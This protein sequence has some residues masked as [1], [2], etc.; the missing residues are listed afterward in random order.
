[1]E[2]EKK[3]MGDLKGCYAISNIT[4]DSQTHIL[5]ATED[6]GKC[7]LF[8]KEGKLEST[9][10]EAPGGTMSFAP[11]PGQ[12]GDFL[13]VQNFYP[14]FDAEKSTIAWVSHQ[15]DGSW[16]TNTVLNL[17]YV[18]RIGIITSNNIKYFVAAV[19]CESKSSI[20][21]WSSA[22]KLYACV[23]PDS[24]DKPFE[25]K[26]VKDNIKKHHGFCFSKYNDKEACYI[27]GDEGLFA[28][29]P[30][31]IPGEDWESVVILERPVSDIAFIDIDGDKQ[32]ELVT[33]EPF[34][35]N[36]FLIYKLID[37]RFEKIYKYP[38]KI[39]FAHVVWGGLLR[40]IPTIIGGCRRE[41]KE[42][43]YIQCNGERPPVFTSHNID[44][45]GGPCNIVVVNDQDKDYIYVTNGETNQI[46]MYT[47]T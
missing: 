25:L 41:N 11:I 45:G 42:L 5:A 40:G 27:S 16:T 2:F 20:D 47:V 15:E 26:V 35:G 7:I 22:G 28:V 6:K 44:T 30:P 10:W 12:N 18:H 31:T 1:M 21:D 4:I 24:S 32:D 38:H 33:I 14:G 17:P 46:V 34:H 37:G 36:E 3:L 19:L 13:A 8:S 23:L 29:L 39:A 9:I 43:F